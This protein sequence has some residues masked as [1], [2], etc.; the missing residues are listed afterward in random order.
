MTN[1]GE[2]VN[3]CLFDESRFFGVL[4]ARLIPLPHNSSLLT[5]YPLLNLR[6]TLEVRAPT[7]P[8]VFLLSRYADKRKYF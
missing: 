4:C 6:L 1:D 5:L 3:A 2:G 8:P 7:L